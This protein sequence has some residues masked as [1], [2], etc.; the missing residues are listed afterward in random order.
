M[1]QVKT[2]PTPREVRTFGLLWLVFFAAV[3]GLSL[4]RPEGLVGAGVVLSLAW[5]VMVGSFAFVIAMVM[6]GG[7]TSLSTTQGLSSM[8]YLALVLL[9]AGGFILRVVG[10]AFAIAVPV[11]PWLLACTALLASM[12]G[13]G[14]RIHELILARRDGRDPGTTRKSLLGYSEPTLRW[15]M[16]GLAVATCVP[17]RCTRRTSAPW[18]SSAP[19]S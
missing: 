2:D 19:G 8:I 3:G 1:I 5:I 12:L 7:Q 15:L 9:V 13:F 18:P 14:K 4:W 16:G 6:G 11:S 17:T 10:G